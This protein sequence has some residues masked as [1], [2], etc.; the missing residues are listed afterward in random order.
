MKAEYI[1]HMGD[2][3]TVANC[4]RVSFGKCRDEFDGSNQKGSDDRLIRYLAHHNHISPFFHPQIMLRV[5]APIF[6]AN[7]LKRHQVG[8]AI[9]EVSRRYVDDDPAIWYPVL[10]RNRPDVNIKQGSAEEITDAELAFGLDECY[11]HSINVSLD[12]YEEI[13]EKGVAP[14]MARSV[15]PQS[16]ETQW[17][18]TGSLYAYARLCRERLAEG[19][20]QE[21]RDIA[22]AM[23][24]I[25]APLFPVSWKAL[26]CAD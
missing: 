18:W 17:I 20:Q 23:T 7:Q 1:M 15:L 10:W 24:N 21:T 11:Q 2:D 13:I 16:M 19:A 26:M 9:N 12:A 6:V 25:I 4:A 5:T 14:E 3:L 22:Q 8:F